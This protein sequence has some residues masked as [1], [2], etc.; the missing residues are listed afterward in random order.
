MCVFMYAIFF[1]V[2]QFSLQ[3]LSCLVSLCVD[4]GVNFKL[5]SYSEILFQTHL[6]VCLTEEFEVNEHHVRPLSSSSDLVQL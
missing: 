4:I 5:L 6:P 3:T 1:S 2:K